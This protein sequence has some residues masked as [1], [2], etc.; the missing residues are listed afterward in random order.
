MSTTSPASP[1]HSRP[2]AAMLTLDSTS[3]LPWLPSRESRPSSGRPPPLHLC[4][5]APLQRKEQF[6][7]INQSWTQTEPR[8]VSEPSPELRAQVFDECK[9][10]ETDSVNLP[11]RVGRG[12][13]APLPF[14]SV[15][16][17]PTPLAPA[18]PPGAPRSSASLLRPPQPCR[19]L[20]G[21]PAVCG[22]AAFTPPRQRPGRPPPP[23]HS[24]ASRP[25]P[26]TSPSRGPPPPAPTLQRA[27]PSPGAVEPRGSLQGCGRGDNSGRNEVKRSR[28]PRHTCLRGRRRGGGSQRP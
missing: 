20:V 16:A 15:G 10:A 21:A 18:G 24:A 4:Y 26:Q 12:A 2:G 27:G 3:S 7:N 13:E 22:P 25:L 23:P 6:I 11:E 14:T 17:S 28:P 19:S 5:Q 8:Q 1:Q 9:Q